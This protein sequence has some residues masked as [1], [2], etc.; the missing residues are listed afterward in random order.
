M[1]NYLIKKSFKSSEIVYMKYKPDGYN[2]K[3]KNVVRAN[4]SLEKIVVIKPSLIDSILTEKIE[5]QISKIIRL[6]MYILNTDDES[7][8]PSDI[9]LALNEIA[10][11]RSII[12]NKYQDYISKDK[13]EALLKKLRVLE[14][15]L[16]IKNLSYDEIYN[17]FSGPKR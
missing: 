13:E 11:V 15:E 6:V 17:S 9:I 3:P 5:K 14:N 2:F 16:R 8:N 1:P 7:T 12:L 10:R 4:I